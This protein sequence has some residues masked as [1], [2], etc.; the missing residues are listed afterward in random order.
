[1]EKFGS[2]KNILD[3]QQCEEELKRHVSRDEGQ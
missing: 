1:M 2:G 3:P